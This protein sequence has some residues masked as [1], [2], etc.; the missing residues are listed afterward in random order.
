MSRERHAGL[1]NDA[2]LDRRRHHRIEATRPDSLECDIEQSD[3]VARIAHIQLTCPRCNGQGSVFDRHPQVVR[4][5]S[6]RAAS[7]FEQ[8]TIDETSQFDLTTKISGKSRGNLCAQFRAD[9]RGLTRGDD[10]T[11][12]RP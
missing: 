8:M 9:A 4:F 3:D 12:S 6:D 1:G 11:G 2:L 7:F 5:D 10:D